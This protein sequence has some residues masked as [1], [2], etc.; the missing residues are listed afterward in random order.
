MARIL[1][2]FVMIREDHAL[3]WIGSRDFTR[4]PKSKTRKVIG[5]GH[6]IHE[7]NKE[8]GSMLCN[9]EPTIGRNGPKKKP[10]KNGLYSL[11]SFPKKKREKENTIGELKK[12]YPRPSPLYLMEDSVE[13]MIIYLMVLSNLWVCFFSIVIF[14]FVRLFPSLFSRLCTKPQLAGSSNSRLLDA[15]VSITCQL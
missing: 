13:I 8:S 7:Q 15:R 11:L 1:R 5:P 3:S 12:Y 6:L 14:F 9:K 4:R 10:H 2:C